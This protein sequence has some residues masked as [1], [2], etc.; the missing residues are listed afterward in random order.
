VLVEEGN[1]DV[2]A[3]WDGIVLLH[4]LQHEHTLRDAG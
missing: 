2:L 1:R 3:A 4:L